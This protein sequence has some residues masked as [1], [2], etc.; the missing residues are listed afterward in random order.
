MSFFGI[1]LLGVNSTVQALP[2]KLADWQW[3]T[4]V[5]NCSLVQSAS[6][7]GGTIKIS[8]T[9]G[10]DMTGMSISSADPIAPSPRV[11]VKKLKDAKLSLLPHEP[12]SAEGW[13]ST[14]RDVREFRTV[15]HHPEFLK[16]LAEASTVQITGKGVEAR[17]LPVRS[18][19]VAAEALRNCEDFKMR[20]WGMDPLLS[21]KLRSRPKL[22]NSGWIRPEDYPLLALRKNVQGSVTVKLSIDGRGIVRSCAPITPDPQSGLSDAT[23][24]AVKRRAKFEPA[25]DTNGNAVPAPYV[26]ITTFRMY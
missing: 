7:M 3:D 22:L 10:S 2:A 19:A 16:M 23:C 24:K 20:E 5:P 21:R 17:Q 1:V 14:A 8:R 13:I 6:P 4:G 15:S 11:E 9:P 12:I 18:A 26:L 25:I